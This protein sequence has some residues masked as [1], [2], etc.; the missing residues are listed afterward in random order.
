M[1][2][3]SGMASGPSR[4]PISSGVW[5]VTESSWKSARDRTS[6]LAIRAHPLKRLT[7]AGVRVTLN[8]DDPPFFLT[9]LA[10]EYS[11]AAAVLGFSSA[12][13]TDLTRTAIKAGFEDDQTR[14]RLLNAIR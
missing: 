5:P 4:I 1:Q 14:A 10:Q 12:E 2:P 9:S 13:L 3:G 7:D 8:A 11:R 6:R